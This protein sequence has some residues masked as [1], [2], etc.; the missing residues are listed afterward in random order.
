MKNLR[1]AG[2]ARDKMS[3]AVTVA[4][5]AV[6]LAVFGAPLVEAATTQRS[7]LFLLSDFSIVGGQARLDRTPEGVAFRVTTR[8]LPTGTYT[9]WWVIYN[10]PEN[11]AVPNRCSPDDVGNPAVLASI[12]RADGFIVE[13]SRERVTLQAGL[14]KSE[15]TPF[16]PIPG[17]ANATL[18]R[19]KNAE[20]AVI[21]RYH[22]PVELDNLWAQ[23]SMYDDLSE[24]CAVACVDLVA[25]VFPRPGT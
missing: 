20:I 25:A 22:G 9:V 12:Q 8:R 13:R 24:Q 15:E 17:F 18:L 19:P 3:L 2:E 10:N 7:P 16:L 6:V 5:A 11:C 23:I 4:L 1:R 14:A 21:L